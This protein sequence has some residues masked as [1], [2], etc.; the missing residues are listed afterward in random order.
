MLAALWSQTYAQRSYGA[1]WRKTC[2]LCC[3][4]HFEIELLEA[5][6]FSFAHQF[7]WACSH[8]KLNMLHPQPTVSSWRW[9]DSANQWRSEG[10]LRALTFSCSAAA[11]G[12]WGVAG[13]Q[14]GV[15][16]AF[17]RGTPMLRTSVSVTALYSLGLQWCIHLRHHQL[18][19]QKER[20]TLSQDWREYAKAGRVTF[21]RVSRRTGPSRD[22]IKKEVMF[23]GTS[24]LVQTPGKR[25]PRAQG[26][27]E[28]FTQNLFIVWLTKN[29][30]EL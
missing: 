10:A 4:L 7:S 2:Q 19:P 14:E 23:R 6:C 22:L 21:N 5:K 9:F 24:C 25:T 18:A 13:K 8:A 1:K 16:G 15:T 3:A 11:H 17:L 30:S 20:T 26:V 27:L 29:L 28:Y 12:C